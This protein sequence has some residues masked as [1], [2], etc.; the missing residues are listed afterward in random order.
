M[1][2]LK[3]AISKGSM[4]D[5]TD[6]VQR[7]ICNCVPRCKHFVSLAVIGEGTLVCD[8]DAKKHLSELDGVLYGKRKAAAGRRYGWTV[9]EEQIIIRIAEEFGRY[10]NGRL[11]NGVIQAIMNE[12][13]RPKAQISSKLQEMRKAGKL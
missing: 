6:K 2:V 1:Y 3:P 5:F 7:K 8:G 13:D 11:R 10:S 9:G 12:L 4:S